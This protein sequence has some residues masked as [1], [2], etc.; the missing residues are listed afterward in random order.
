MDAASL[1]KKE[2][3]N[4]CAF[5]RVRRGESLPARRAGIL[6]GLRWIRAAAPCLALSAAGTDPRLMLL[7]REE[8]AKPSL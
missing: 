5:Q 8:Q 6:S 1:L 3:S 2:H 4:R 7:A